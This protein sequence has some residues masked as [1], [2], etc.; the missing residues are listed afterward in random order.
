MDCIGFQSGKSFKKKHKC[1]EIEVW[2]SPNNLNTVANHSV[3]LPG[4]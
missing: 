2:L 3:D 4:K 1:N